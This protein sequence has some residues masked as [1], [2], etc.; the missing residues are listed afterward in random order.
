MLVD[1]AFA[2]THGVGDHFDSDAV[3]T[4]FEKQLE[5]GVEDFL[6]ATAKLTDLT[7]FFLHRKDWM[8]IEAVYY[9]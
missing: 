7:R 1:R 3:L 4:L 6:F 2:D 5:R 9:A 8:T